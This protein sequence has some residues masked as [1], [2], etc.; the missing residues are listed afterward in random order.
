[1]ER[2]WL[3]LAEELVG[4]CSLPEAAVCDDAVVFCAGRFASLLNTDW[5]T[6]GGRITRRD[7]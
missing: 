2:R 3:W 6:N 4:A 7:Q 1:M 5:E